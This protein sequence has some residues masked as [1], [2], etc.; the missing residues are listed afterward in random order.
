MAEML[1]VYCYDVSDNRNRR[2]LSGILE[3]RCVRVQRSVFEARLTRRDAHRIARRA[4][5][6]LALALKAALEPRGHG[7]RVQQ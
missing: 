3:D 2:R 5:R 7:P 4:A 6:E 1:V